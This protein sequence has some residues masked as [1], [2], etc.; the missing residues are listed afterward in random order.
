MATASPAQT[1]Y[2]SVAHQPKENTKEKLSFLRTLIPTWKPQRGEGRGA[3]L[4]WI[5]TVL[6]WTAFAC[7][8]IPL[9]ATPTLYMW[10][11]NAGNTFPVPGT[12]SMVKDA[13]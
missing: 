12:V 11:D 3:S 2:D 6:G 13:V 4:E 7:L 10:R 5:D 1:F 8:I 9:F